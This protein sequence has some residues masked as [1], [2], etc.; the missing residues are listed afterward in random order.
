MFMNL[1]VQDFNLLFTHFNVT[2]LTF[3]GWFELSGITPHGWQLG[4]INCPAIVET[5]VGAVKM[6][7]SF[8][9]G[10]CCYVL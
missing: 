4:F 5:A 10:D 9:E 6:Y 3:C 2:V 7:L 1:N 8:S